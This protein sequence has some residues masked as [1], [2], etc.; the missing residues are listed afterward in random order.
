MWRIKRICGTDIHRPGSIRRVR[1]DNRPCEGVVRCCDVD[2]EAWE[3]AAEVD[4]AAV[5]HC[6]VVVVVIILVGCRGCVG[7][8]VE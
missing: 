3:V 6:I 2:L 4:E 1:L 8:M 5:D 7:G